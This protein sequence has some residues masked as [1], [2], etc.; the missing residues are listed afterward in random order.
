MRRSITILALCTLATFAA[1]AAGAAPSAGLW[2]G[3]VLL[4][5]VSAADGGAPQGTP[6][7]LVLK[8]L[9]HMDADGNVRLLKQVILMWQNGAT[10]AAAGH[11]ALVTD[12]TKIPDF[13]GVAQRDG[14]PVGKRISA[15]GFDFPGDSLACTGTLGTSGT[16]ACTVPIAA[17]AGT[18]PFLHRYHPDH[19]NKASDFTSAARPAEVNAVTRAITLQFAAAPA[20]AASAPPG[21]GATLVGGT[22]AEAISGL[23]KPGT[24]ITIQGGFTL[25]RYSDRAVLNQ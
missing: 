19:D 14:D 21:W 17:D 2:A 12:D 24:A 20:G 6:A 15:V 23:G 22:Y 11:Y 16:V 10:P 1:S 3:S 5:K 18:N 9:L 8:L 25:E 13:T 7:P 4:D